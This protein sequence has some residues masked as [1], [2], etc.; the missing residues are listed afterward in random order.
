LIIFSILQT[1]AWFLVGVFAGLA[2]D[3]II[4]TKKKQQ[5]DLFQVTA[6]Y[7]TALLFMVTVTLFLTLATSGVI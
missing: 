7:L 4:E 3:A 6:L 1:S 2:A 5:N